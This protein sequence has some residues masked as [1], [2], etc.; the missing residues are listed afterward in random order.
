M[1]IRLKLSLIIGGILLVVMFVITSA[2]I[3]QQQT[4]L[5]KKND[6]LCKLLVQNLSSTAKDQLILSSWLPIQEAVSNIGKQ[7]IE[8]V[9]WVAVTDRDGKVIAHTDLNLTSKPMPPL[10]ASRPVPKALLADSSL[11]LYESEKDFVYTDSIFVRRITTEQGSK[12]EQRIFLGLSQASLSKEPLAALLA[13]QRQF[14]V[15]IGLTVLAVSILLV[16]VMAKPIVSAIEAIS[17][18][19][20]KVGAGDLTVT[21]ITRS[22]DELGE[23][24]QEFNKMVRDIREKKR[25]EQYVSDLTVEMIRQDENLSMGG[26]RLLVTVLFSDVRGFTAMSENLEPEKVVEIINV[27]LNL[28]TEVIQKHYG[29]IDKF[30]GDGIMALF[31]G[32]NAADHAINAALEIQHEMSRCNEARNALGETAAQVGIGINTGYA[33]LGNIGSASRKD[34]TAVGDTVNLASRLCSAATGSGVLI[35]ETVLEHTGFQY[36]LK[37]NQAINV[38]GKSAPVKVYE[39]FGVSLEKS[40]P[41]QA[42]EVEPHRR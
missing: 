29:S 33:V 10:P 36:M 6:E 5:T 41:Q 42:V 11:A 27:Y 35:A 24:A 37:N 25:M 18:A 20:R 38:K 34:F 9:N 28:Q 26:S 8:G 19:A 31:I 22:R 16:F 15:M 40:A 13:A 1:R 14:I 7:H 2:V 30:M 32:D 39:V 23:L 3:T 4:A 17:G 21:V 12:I